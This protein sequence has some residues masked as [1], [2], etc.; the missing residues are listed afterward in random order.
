MV[1]TVSGTYAFDLAIDEMINTASRRAGGEIVT[2]NEASNARIALNLLL[3]DIQNKGVPLA[4]VTKR[5]LALVEGQ[6]E[7][8]LPTQVL[9]ILD[10]TLKRDSNETE[11]EQI[12][13]LEYSKYNMKSEQGFPT[14]FAVNKIRNALKI[15]V[16]MCPE[17]STDTFEYYAVDRIDDIT[18]SYQLANLSAQYLPAMVAG[19]AHYM[20]LERDGIPD[21]KISRLKA[22]YDELLKLTFDTDS[23]GS[24]FKAQPKVN[25]P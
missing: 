24:T 16:Y 21:A 14:Q 1:E 6:I 12:S 17:N 23:E 19:L 5:S 11:M 4:R 13:L 10:A 3:I 15:E 20:S 2:G 25:R 8:T 9:Y 7:Y 18:S 22:H